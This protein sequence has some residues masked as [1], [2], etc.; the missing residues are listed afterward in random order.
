MARQVQK[1][2]AREGLVMGK[3][4]KD[5]GIRNI[6]WFVYK[7]WLQDKKSVLNMNVELDRCARSYCM[8]NN[9]SFHGPLKKA[10]DDKKRTVL[11][12]E[13]ENEMRV[14]ATLK[15]T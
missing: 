14:S 6:R 3:E 13:N 8:I 4:E 2:V 5:L 7:Q 9:I 1:K 12:P 15:R 11:L 10:P